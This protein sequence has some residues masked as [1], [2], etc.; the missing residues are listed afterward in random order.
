MKYKS[1]VII[2]AGPI[3]GILAAHLIS[4]GH[5][6]MLADSW[7]D[8]IEQMRTHGL[9]I[10]GRQELCVHPAHLYASIEDLGDIEPDF[11]F[12]CTKACDLDAVLDKIG[13]AIRKSRAVFISFQNGIDTENVIAERFGPSRVLRGALTYAGVLIGPGKI[14]W[15]FFNPPNYLGWLDEGGMEAC[16]DVA[17]MLSDAGLGTEATGEIGH[18]VW[19]KAILNTCTMA[20]AAVTGMNMQEMEEF[21]PTSQLVDLLLHESIA[22]AAANGFDYGPGFFETVKD[23]NKLAGPHRPSMLVDI[24]NGRKTENAFI[25]RRIAEYADRKGVPAPYHRTLAILIDALELRNRSKLMK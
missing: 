15:S 3:G 23:F 17:A 18:H 4:A 25:V 24:E 12:I 11:V 10:S 8:H 14:R 2:G 6:V 20:I 21:P 22:V 19:R 7:R 1:I 16:K 13:N 9:Y 5:K